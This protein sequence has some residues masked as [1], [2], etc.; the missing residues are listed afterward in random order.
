MAR[1]ELDNVGLTFRVRTQG[2][3]R[4]IKETF[5]NWLR[6][7]WASDFMEVRALEGLSLTLTAGQRV[8]VIGH[9]GAGKSTLLRLLAGVY[10][11]TEGRRVVE[12]K[13]SSLFDLMLG[14]EGDATGWEN[15][16]YRG[17]LQG[18]TPRSIGRKLDGIAEFT[19]L[20]K[21]LD[22]PVRYY[23]AGMLVRLAFA[24]STAIEPEVLLIDEVLGAGDAEFQA[25]ARAR[26]QELMGR[27]RLIVCVSHDMGSLQEFCDWGLWL[28]RGRLRQQGPLRDVIA[29]YHESLKPA[30]AAA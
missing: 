29:A 3:R 26:L 22:M 4:T 19:G 7:R 21:F 24:I 13:V 30:P 10:E 1:I 28:E 6:G 12:G 11:P 14:F 2:G 15:I 8:A 20:G 16:R 9:N 17:Y 27:A 18:E 5:L 23:S 25:R